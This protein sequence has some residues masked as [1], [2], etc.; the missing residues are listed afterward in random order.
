MP[1]SLGKLAKLYCIDENGKKTEVDAKFE[2]GKIIFTANNFSTYTIVYTFSLL[3]VCIVVVLITAVVV[4]AI[5]R[6]K[7]KSLI[8]YNY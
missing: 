8:P 7:K 6:K 4:L 5:I 3:S 2:N 1:P